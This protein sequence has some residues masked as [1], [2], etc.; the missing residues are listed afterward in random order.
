MVPAL[1]RRIQIVL[2]RRRRYDAAEGGPPA[3][4]WKRFKFLLAGFALAAVAVAILVLAFILGSIVAAALWVLA[5]T[6][7]VV[8]I[9]RSA[10]RQNK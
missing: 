6:V 3:T 8:A 4:L 2:S 9:F 1:N 5:A 7:L 10:W